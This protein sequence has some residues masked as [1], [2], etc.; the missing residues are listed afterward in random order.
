MKPQGM[1]LAWIV[2][3]DI[4]EAIKFYT[5]V[6]GL[7]LAEFNE[8]YGWAE[9]IGPAGARLGLAQECSTSE[10]KA[11]KNAVMTLSVADIE[12]ARE[13]LKAKGVNLLGEIM[14]VPGIVKMQT[15][16][17][18]DGNMFQLCQMLENHK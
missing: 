1:F 18:A 11:G 16:K 17:D 8:M 10:I 5:E 2:V 4:K 9:L 7:T 12:Q 13:D 6:I 15:F 3:A 14:E